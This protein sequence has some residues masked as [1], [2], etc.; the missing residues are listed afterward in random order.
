MK[1]SRSWRDAFG[2]EAILFNPSTNPLLAGITRKPLS[3]DVAVAIRSAIFAGHMKPGDRILETELAEQLQVSRG[4]VREAL[5]QLEQE[6][7]VARLPH[8]GTF[9]STLSRQD[10]HEIYTLRALLD[11]EA[12]ALAAGR[13]TAQDFATLESLLEEFDRAAQ[14][15]SLYALAQ[16]DR[17]FH[18]TVIKA[19]GHGRLMQA[20]NNVEPLIG[21]CYLTIM[22]AMPHRKGG[23]VARHAPLIEVL[24][25]GD[26]E[27]ARHA[28]SQHYLESWEALDRVMPPVPEYVAQA[29]D[30]AREGRKN[31]LGA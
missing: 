29:S 30:L 20:C 5:A 31:S 27:A 26:P 15:D 10:A 28:F 11:G 19:A 18:G 1:R 6:G 22:T 21:A 4:P 14:C 2:Q 12:A 16:T 24:R 23:L 17:T 3:H 7:L 8:R 13:L 25:T 9:V